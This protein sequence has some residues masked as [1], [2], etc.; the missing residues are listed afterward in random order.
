VTDPMISTPDKAFH[1]ADQDMNPGSLS[2]A[3]NLS[4]VIKRHI[5]HVV[6]RILISFYRLVI[7]NVSKC[8]V[9]DMRRVHTVDNLNCS[10]AWRGSTVLHRN[11]NGRFIRCTASAFTSSGRTKVGI[12]HLNDVFLSCLKRKWSFPRCELAILPQEGN[13]WESNERST[14][15]SRR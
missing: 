11:N 15:L 6:R 5:K 2:M 3:H 9:S 13:S 12:I 1:I 8:E 4:V 7:L 14:V 10:I